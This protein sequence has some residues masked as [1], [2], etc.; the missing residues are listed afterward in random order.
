MKQ[1]MHTFRR[2]SFSFFFML[3]VMQMLNIVALFL[4]FAPMGANISR[5]ANTNS[6]VI[7]LVFSICHSLIM[8]DEESDKMGMKVRLALC[9]FLC[10]PGCALLV[11]N[12]GIPSI[13]LRLLQ[14]GGIAVGLN[15]AVAVWWIATI[16]NFLLFTTIYFLCEIRYYR[17]S[18]RYTE[19][20]ADYKKK[21][22]QIR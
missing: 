10:L 17:L 1:I 21:M 4:P 6:L 11:Y 12:F 20:L 5:I 9:G 22:T 14:E 19:A 18:K 7:A 15:D 16:L 2:W 3:G 13:F 8:V